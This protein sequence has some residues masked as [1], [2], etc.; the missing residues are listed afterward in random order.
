LRLS[1]EWLLY[2]I[3]CLSD[4]RTGTGLR[5]GIVHARWNTTMI[6]ALLDGAKKALA[7]AGVKD[8]NIVVQSVPG[9]YELPYAVK[10][11][12]KTPFCFYYLVVAN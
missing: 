10:Q 5:I 7:K 8:E 1:T 4:G 11:Y 3:C 12:V 6:D 2:L 9:S